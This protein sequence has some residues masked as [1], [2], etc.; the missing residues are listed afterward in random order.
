MLSSSIIFYFYIFQIVDPIIGEI[1]N[2][3]LHIV[4]NFHIFLKYFSL[5]AN[6]I[7]NKKL[8]LLKQIFYSDALYLSLQKKGKKEEI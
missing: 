5:F 7:L 2:I 1:W 4:E 6:I 3:I 8:L